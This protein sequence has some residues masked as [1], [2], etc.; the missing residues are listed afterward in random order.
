MIQYRKDI[1]TC[2]G[3]ER[4]IVKRLPG[5]K[6]CN[7]GNEARLSARREKKSPTGE[8]AMFEEIW[9]SR[10]H[11]SFLSGQDVSKYYDSPMFVNL[12]AHVLSKAKNR[13]PEYKLYPENIA[14]LTP[15]EHFLFDQGNEA[16]RQR[17]AEENNCSWKPLFDLKKALI[18][19]YP[20]TEIG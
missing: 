10:E 13:Y 1:C 8:Y 14:L 3:K 17:Y 15:K 4:L 5:R 18:E 2:H 6:L 12:F 11:K 7:V 16:Q 9:A 19:R 20:D